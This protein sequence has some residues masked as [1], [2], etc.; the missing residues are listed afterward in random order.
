[1]N[2]HSGP[3]NLV[4]L[5]LVLLIAGFAGSALY[6]SLSPEPAFLAV[7]EDYGAAISAAAVTNGQ[8]ASSLAELQWDKVNKSARLVEAHGHILFLCIFLMLFAILLNGLQGD[9]RYIRSNAWLGIGG[10]LIY[11]AGLFTQSTGLTLPGQVLSAAG[12]LLIVAFAGIMVARLWRHG[13]SRRS[14]DTGHST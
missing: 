13:I 2:V 4:S 1:M 11:P 5:A 6:R 10:V 12:A 3:R 7:Q 8:T 14:P 9:G